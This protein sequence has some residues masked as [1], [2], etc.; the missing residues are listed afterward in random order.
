MLRECRKVCTF[1]LKSAYE[2]IADARSYWKSGILDQLTGPRQQLDRVHP[3]QQSALPAY[4]EYIKTPS[5]A[6]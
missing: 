4:M 3:Q 2:G 1:L 6:Q 5:L